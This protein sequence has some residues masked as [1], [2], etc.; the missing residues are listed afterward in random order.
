MADIYSSSLSVSPTCNVKRRSRGCGPESGC[1]SPL[2]LDFLAPESCVICG[3]S[4]SPV[5]P[6][7]TDA[8]IAEWKT[9]GRVHYLF[10]YAGVATLIR[11]WKYS[12]RW[13]AVRRLVYSRGCPK[14]LRPD[15]LL[16]PVPQSRWRFA[17]RGYNQARQLANWLGGLSGLQV[18]DCLREPWRKRQA[19][20]A[21]RREDRWAVRHP[22]IVQQ[23]RFSGRSAYLVDDVYTTGHTIETMSLLLESSRITV[24]GVIVLAKV[25]LH[26]NN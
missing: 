14:G 19:H 15:A 11:R 16:I 18:V 24:V 12:G 22:R 10:D 1:Q 9:D 25:E 2:W 8:F 17:E 21:A 3:R 5:C 4:E 26:R 13:S 23:E 7:C 6:D 20:L